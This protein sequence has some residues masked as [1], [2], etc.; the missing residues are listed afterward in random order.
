MPA[1][2]YK[3]NVVIRDPA[4]YRAPLPLAINGR[5]TDGSYTLSTV[6]VGTASTPTEPTEPTTPTT[7]ETPTSDPATLVG[8]VILQGRP[9][10]P[11]A[12]WQVPLEVTLFVESL[13]STPT[14]YEVTTDENGRFTIG[15]IEPGSYIIRV[16]NPHTLQQTVPVS[17]VSG[18][19]NISFGTLL[20]GDV[21]N[22]NKITAVDS[23]L[24]MNSYN[25]T[26]EDDQFDGRADLNEDG[27][28]DN[29]DSLLLAANYTE[30]EAPEPG[31]NVSA[32]ISSTG[33]CNG[34][35]VQLVLEAAT[36][37]GPF[38]VVVNGKTYNDI[39]I[40][41]VINSTTPSE[42]LWTTEPVARTYEDS[43][44]ELGVKFKSSIPG[45]VK[46]IR[47]FSPNNIEGTYTGIF[48]L[49]QDSCW[50]APFFK[51]LPLTAGRKYY[52]ISR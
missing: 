38:D 40:G 35:P 4:N 10:A 41:A 30:V 50:R 25:A 11:Q 17:L 6:N 45:F 48:G 37:A 22:D 27:R 15:S 8:T 18:V 12:Q 52:S 7:P 1:G 46:G 44:V 42:Q 33:G 5:N 49:Q 14:K 2:R 24:L 3:L 32:R 43:P 51:T 9:E 19:N 16:K 26:E 39:Q 20:E 34:E 29:T 28:V 47:F 13:S 21:N 36:G 31:C 23:S